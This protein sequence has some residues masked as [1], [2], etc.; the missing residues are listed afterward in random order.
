MRLAQLGPVLWRA[1]RPASGLPHALE[2]GTCEEVAD[3]LPALDIP[4]V[5]LRVPV[6]G[7]PTDATLKIICSGVK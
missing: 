3:V 1:I 4:G 7:K 2:F 6:H 5:L